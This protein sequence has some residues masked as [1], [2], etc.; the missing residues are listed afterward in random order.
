MAPEELLAAGHDALAAGRWSDARA[1]LR[2]G[3]GGRRERGGLLRPG[4]GPVVVG[5]EPR[6]RGARH[7]CLLAVP[8]TRRHARRGACAVWLAIT[9]KANFANFAAANGWVGRA[10]RLLEAARAR[11]PARLGCGSPAPTGWPTSTPPRSSPSGPWRWPATAARCR[12]RA[13]RAVPAG[14]DRRGQ[15]RH[16]RRLR[17]HR[18][19]DGG[20]AGRGALHASTRSSTPAATCSTPASWP[21]DL[22]RAEQWCRVADDFVATYGCPFLYAECRFYYGS[23]LAAKGRWADAE[24]EL[25]AGLRITEGACPALHDRALTRLA[26]LRVRQGR[27]E[28]AE[29]LLDGL[30]ARA[31]ADAEVDALGGGAA[32]GPRRRG[33]RQPRARGARRTSSP[34]I[35]RSWP[36]RS[37]CSSTPTSPPATSPP[38]ERRRI[39]WREVV[40][41]AAISAGISAGDDRLSALVD[42][43]SGRLAMARGDSV[44]A[45][46]VVRGRGWPPWARHGLP[47]EAARA[48]FEL[49]RPLASDPPD[50]A[51]DHARRALASFDELGAAL[52]ADRAAA[53]LRSLGV[54]ARTGAKGVGTLTTGSR[55]CCASSAPVCPTPR[56]PRASTS[57]ARPRPTT[58]AASWPSST[59]GTGP[60]RRPS[61]PA[62][63]GAPGSAT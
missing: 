57:A 36:Q 20:G 2:G 62:A 54:T 14:P 51:V 7:P 30:S 53:F 19:G 5:R 16:R 49:A 34:G 6:Q 39:A 52:E 58:S 48:R 11:G 9:Y 35:A 43:A 8:A 17:A 40:G 26:V 31:E 61:P 21:S 63:T 12:P 1:R 23:V 10:E 33:R 50:A 59:C 37:T 22:E 56:S 24:R 3:L 28:E 18:R 55:R 32:A 42:L 27:L 41:S 38:P 45:V 15:G 25:D 60:R 47:F 44:A 13:R 29:R 46:S 4:G